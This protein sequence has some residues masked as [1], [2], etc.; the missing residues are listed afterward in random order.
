MS[1]RLLS[2]VFKYTRMNS[3]KTKGPKL[4]LERERGSLVRAFQ[5]CQKWRKWGEKGELAP[6]FISTSPNRTTFPNDP[7]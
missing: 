7:G 3:E 5:K 1:G 4:E 6:T 2:L